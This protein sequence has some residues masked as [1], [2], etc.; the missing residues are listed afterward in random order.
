MCSAYVKALG[1]KSHL[2]TL[3]G[4]GKFLMKF[5]SFDVSQRHRIHFG[6]LIEYIVIKGWKVFKNFNV[7]NFSK[8]LKI[9]QKVQSFPKSLQKLVKLLQLLQKF[10]KVFVSWKFPIYYPFYGFPL[11]CSP[12]IEFYLLP[13]NNTSRSHCYL[14]LKCLQHHK[15]FWESEMR[16]R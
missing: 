13:L 10:E 12:K 15:E 9:L 3:Y 1:I 6:D 16:T 7:F 4:M 14:L 5:R 11:T 2:L 8:N